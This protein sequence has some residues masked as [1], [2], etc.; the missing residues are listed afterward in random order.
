MHEYSLMEQVIAHILAELNKQAETPTGSELSVVLKVGA[1]A[2]HSEAA[3]RQAY[4]VLVKG[5]PLEN[6]RLLLTIEPVAL[7]CEK[8]G[9]KESLPEGAVDPHD[10]SP[11]VECPRCGAVTP[12]QGGR[13]VESIELRWE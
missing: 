4:E 10:L 13:G 7:D 11:L 9:Y 8:C 5:T 12:V 3:T 2:V 1:L 6:S